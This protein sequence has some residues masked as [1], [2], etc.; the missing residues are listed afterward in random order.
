MFF[1][2]YFINLE[3]CGVSVNKKTLYSKTEFT[4][5]PFIAQL[6]VFPYVCIEKHASKLK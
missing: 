3:L 2:E 5:P 1:L 4:S 6:A